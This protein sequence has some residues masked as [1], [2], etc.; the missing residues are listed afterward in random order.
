MSSFLKSIFH[1][2]NKHKKLSEEWTNNREPVVDGVTFYVRYLGS[3]VVD[4]PKSSQSTAAGVKRII[5]AAKA[6]AR[7]PDRVAFR[8]SMEGVR[9]DSTGTGETLMDTSIYKISYC[10]ADSQYEQVLA[11]VASNEEETCECFAFLCSKRKVAEAIAVSIAQAFTMAY[12]CWKLALE[13]KRNG[14][15]NLSS[16]MVAGRGIASPARSKDGGDG[17]CSRSSSP[18]H[19]PGY[20]STPSE[21]SSTSGYQSSTPGGLLLELDYNDAGSE[22]TLATVADHQQQSSAVVPRKHWIDFGSSEELM[23]MEPLYSPRSTSNRELWQFPARL[24]RRP[25]TPSSGSGRGAGGLGKHDTLRHNCSF[26]S[27]FRSS[28]RYSLSDS[29]QQL[30]TAVN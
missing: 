26:N 11:F 8:V 17:N 3:S 4:D 2:S 20:S 13:A 23:S 12:E 1:S 9:I 25:E 6:G 28:S 5:H 15:N 24:A 21:V 29:E 18:G 19:S 7:R 14:Q 27:G 16:D 10:S 22:G 30:L